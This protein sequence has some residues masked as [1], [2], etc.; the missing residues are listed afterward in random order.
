[1]VRWRWSMK[2]CRWSPSRRATICWKSSNPISHEVRARGGKLYVFAD[3]KAGMQQ[4]GRHHRHRNAGARDRTASARSSSP[5]RCNCWLITSRYSRAPTSISRAIWRR[6]S[7]SNRPAFPLAHSTRPPFA[8]EGIDHVLLLVS[9][10]HEAVQFYSD[11]LGCGI[12]SELPE[13]AMVQ[14]RAGGAL[15]DLVRRKRGCGKMGAS[16]DHGRPQPR[17]LVYRHCQ[18]AMNKDFAAIWPIM[19]WK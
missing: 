2:T 17:S 14:P 9:G 4:R 11:V 6:V 19:A 10:M 15:I 12:E 16:Q 13:F 1:M 3:P 5:S 18:I 8:L 7:R